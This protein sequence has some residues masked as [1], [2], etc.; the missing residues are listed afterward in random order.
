MSEQVWQ[1]STQANFNLDRLESQPWRSER[2]WFAWLSFGVRSYTTATWY[3]A[4]GGFGSTP[5]EAIDTASS[6]IQ[7]SI[8]TDLLEWLKKAL[9]KLDESEYHRLNPTPGVHSRALELG[10]LALG[11]ESRSI[12][13]D[14]HGEE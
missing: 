12:T 11:G 6:E 3:I 2:P 5:Q 10:H 13:P 1:F 9:V 8:R 4:R 14:N 7:T